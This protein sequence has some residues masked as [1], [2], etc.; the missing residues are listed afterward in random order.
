M[1]IFY[2]KYENPFDARKNPFNIFEILKIVQ[3]MA[4]HHCFIIFALFQVSVGDEESSNL[5]LS[6]PL[7]LH[8]CSQMVHTMD[9]WEVSEAHWS[10]K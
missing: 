8:W 1:I 9:D 3:V 2:Y 6:F 4:C 5:V 7:L 10:C